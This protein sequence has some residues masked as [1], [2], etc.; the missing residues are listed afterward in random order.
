MKELNYNISELI[1]AYKVWLCENTTVLD[2]RTLS[3]MRGLPVYVDMSCNKLYIKGIREYQGTCM[4]VAID[5]E[6]AWEPVVIHST[7]RAKTNLLQDTE[8]VTTDRIRVYGSDVYSNMLLDDKIMFFPTEFLDSELFSSEESEEVLDV[9]IDLVKDVAL[10]ISAKYDSLV[11][12]F[13]NYGISSLDGVDHVDVKSMSESEKESL[14]ITDT[15]KVVLVSKYIDWR[16]EVISIVPRSKLLFHKLGVNLRTANTYTKLA[17]VD[18]ERDHS[19]YVG[20]S[21]IF[22][23]NE[24]VIPKKAADVIRQLYSPSGWVSPLSA[25]ELA[26][27][28][29]SLCAMAVSACACYTSNRIPESQVRHAYNCLG[30]TKSLWSVDDALDSF[31]NLGGQYVP[32]KFVGR[33][34]IVSQFEQD[35]PFVGVVRKVNA[36]GYYEIVSRN[37][38]IE[39]S[40]NIWLKM[41]KSGTIRLGQDFRDEGYCTR[42][43]WF[44]LLWYVDLLCNKDTAGKIFDF[45][46]FIYA[47]SRGDLVVTEYFVNKY[48]PGKTADE[49]MGSFMN[50]KNVLNFLQSAGVTSVSNA[51]ASGKVCISAPRCSNTV[52][53]YRSPFSLMK[54]VTYESLRKD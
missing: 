10:Y 23:N 39:P 37:R 25:D 54:E 46:E 27:A 29:K 35:L 19:V 16:G 9:N 44:V 52:L 2:G 31:V 34:E 53:L 24:T 18:K 32:A 12:S 36:T 1:E 43:P 6:S 50:L 3:L 11:E 45:G 21:L 4:S 49:V 22:C 26:D 20:R 13:A 41:P 47:T 14:G 15:C 51:A 48:F 5:I 40:Y 30:I 33:T 17:F 42:V 7:D 28:G 38:V 8:L